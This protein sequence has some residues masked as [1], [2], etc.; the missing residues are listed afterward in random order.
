V[1]THKECPLLAPASLL[2][3]RSLLMGCAQSAKPAAR[4]LPALVANKQ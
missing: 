4:W 3:G 1:A 2:S